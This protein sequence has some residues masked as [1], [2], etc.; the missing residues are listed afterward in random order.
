MS[1]S[2]KIFKKINKNKNRSTNTSADNYQTNFVSGQM[3]EN[4]KKS[5]KKMVTTPKVQLYEYPVEET[6]SYLTNPEESSETKS[7]DQILKSLPRRTY[8]SSYESLNK[9]LISTQP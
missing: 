5:V 7:D 4:T 8:P 9:N 1:E 2:E 3:K 6:I